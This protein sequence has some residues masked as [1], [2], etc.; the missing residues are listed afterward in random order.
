MR[1]QSKKAITRFCLNLAWYV[2]SK[3]YTTNIIFI[4]MGHL[5][6][7]VLHY[8]KIG[9][10]HSSQKPR[11]LTRGQSVRSRGLH[12]SDTECDVNMWYKRKGELCTPS[13]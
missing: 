1:V 6:I 10:L 3:H 13:Q 8:S 11:R 2:Y 12:P 5:K 4:H 9:R 7:P